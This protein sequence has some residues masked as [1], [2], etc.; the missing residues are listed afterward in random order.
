MLVDFAISENLGPVVRTLH[1]QGRE[2]DS[3]PGQGTGGS[4]GGS[5]SKESTSNAGDVRSLGWEDPLEEGMATHSGILAWRIPRTE[6]PH[7]L[8][9]MGLQRVRH[10]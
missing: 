7:G 2:S 8:Q 5:A 4:P 3:V 6:G 1:S 9:P 10:D